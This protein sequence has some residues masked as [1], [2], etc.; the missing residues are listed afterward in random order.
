MTQITFKCLSSVNQPIDL[1]PIR[2]GRPLNRLEIRALRRKFASKKI[3]PHVMGALIAALVAADIESGR[4]APSHFWAK[5]PSSGNFWDRLILEPDYRRVYPLTLPTEFIHPLGT[6]IPTLDRRELGRPSSGK[7]LLW[8]EIRKVVA[9]LEELERAGGQDPNAETIA[10]AI[11]DDLYFNVEISD[12]YPLMA[13]LAIASLRWEDSTVHEI[14]ALLD[15]HFES[16]VEEPFTHHTMRVLFMVMRGAIAGRDPFEE[17]DRQIEALPD[18]SKEFI[19][20]HVEKHSRDNTSFCPDQALRD[21]LQIL[22][23]LKGSSSFKEAFSQL[24]DPAMEMRYWGLGKRVMFAAMSGGFFGIHR[25]PSELSTYVRVLEDTQEGLEIYNLSDLQDLALTLAGFDS[26][27]DTPPETAVGPEKVAENLYAANLSGAFDIVRYIDD[28]DEWVIISLCRT[29]TR[30]DQL[31]HRRVI[32]LIDK[33]GNINPDLRSVVLDAVNEIDKHLSEGRKV[34]VHCHGGRSRT[35]LI[36]KAWKMRRDGVDEAAAHE[37]LTSTWKHANR[38]NS[39][40]VDFLKNEWPQIVK[41]SNR[42]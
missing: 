29:G 28:L 41:E 23:A 33:E 12:L 22:D 24:N 30:F 32:Y 35:A 7:R 40:F 26:I 1:W 15:P 20:N 25:I 2:A 34:L 4:E 27:S 18:A 11:I 31:T 3:K 37:W 21:L 17:L 36:L 16:I 6:W 38:K 19:R 39:T 9:L 5:S 8:N 42:G 13:V 14:L 10:S